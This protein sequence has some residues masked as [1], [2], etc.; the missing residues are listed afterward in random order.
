LDPQFFKIF[1]KLRT[2]I[3]QNNL[4]DQQV[5]RRSE[6]DSICTVCDDRFLKSSQNRE[7]LLIR[8]IYQV[9]KFKGVPKETQSI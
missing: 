3:D 9:G 5:Q 4:P 2:F 6:G 1:P 7:H 8:T